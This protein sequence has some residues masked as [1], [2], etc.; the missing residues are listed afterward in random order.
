[1]I[2]DFLS[3]LDQPFAPK[4]VTF[5]LRLLSLILVF[6]C[7]GALLS[8]AIQNIWSMF[9]LVLLILPVVAIIPLACAEIF[10]S[11]IHMSENMDQT[12]EEMRRLRLLNE[13]FAKGLPLPEFDIEPQKEESQPLKIEKKEKPKKDLFHHKAQKEPKSSQKDDDIFSSLI[14]Q[15]DR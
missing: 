15:P 3:H 1:M 7:V 10:V 12:K 14:E 2:K 4:K 9:L 13:A 8:L 11:I 5:L 6:I